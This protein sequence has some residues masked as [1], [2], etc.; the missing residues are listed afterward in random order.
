MLA[1]PVPSLSPLNDDDRLITYSTFLQLHRFPGIAEVA[2]EAPERQ[3]MA[4]MLETF[5]QKKHPGEKAKAAGDAFLKGLMVPLNLRKAMDIEKVDF[6]S[7][8]LAER[9]GEEEGREAEP[10]RDYVSR[11]KTG[12]WSLLPGFWTLL[13]Q[14]VKDKRDFASEN[15]RHTASSFCHSSIHPSIHSFI[16][17]LCCTAARRPTESQTSRRP[18]ATPP[19]HPKR[20]PSTGSR[21]LQTSCKPSAKAGTPASTATTAPNW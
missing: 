2:E 17:Q 4:S 10:I 7:Y 13:V 21:R 6:T 9:E 15:E 8:P 3:E 18:P 1:S 19:R 5:T 11:I 20:L 12:V 16:Y 14:L